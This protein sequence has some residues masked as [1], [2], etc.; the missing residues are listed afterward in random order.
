MILLHDGRNI[1]CELRVRAT[2]QYDDVTDHCDGL[3]SGEVRFPSQSLGE[4]T[5]G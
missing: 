3:G 2:A 1:L 4:Q 5:E